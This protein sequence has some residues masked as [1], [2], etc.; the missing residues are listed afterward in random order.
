[1]RTIHKL[2]ALMLVI[3]CSACSSL[4]K[5]KD[6]FS[7]FHHQEDFN[8]ATLGLHKV[9][10]LGLIDD[11][12]TLS[13]KEKEQLTHEVYRIFAKRVDG[14]N[15][16]DT[17]ELANHLGIDSYQQTAQAA[18]QGTNQEIANAFNGGESQPSRYLLVM[19]LTDSRDL[20]ADIDRQRDILFSARHCND[21]GWALGL[22]MSIIDTTDGNQ[23]W[24]GHINKDNKSRHCEDDHHYFDVDDDSDKDDAKS[25]LAALAVI[26]V[27]S[28]IVDDVND[29]KA[30]LTRNDFKPLFTEVVH[31][32]AQVL[33]SIYFR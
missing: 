24:G 29:D 10:I 15:L 25:A 21:Y 16:V 11:T 28:A 14:E 17:Q 2:L 23:V 8:I 1:M 12:G 20:G 19:R 18:K 6:K 3:T 22:T 13:G 26:F 4:G 9:G 31:D 33:P 30:S 32:F 7:Y 27:V 5:S